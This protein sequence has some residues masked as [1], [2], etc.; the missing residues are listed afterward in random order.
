MAAALEV[1]SATSRQTA[2]GAK[3]ART[4]SRSGDSSLKLTPAHSSD[5]VEG[6]GDHFEG[7]AAIR[8]FLENWFGTYEELEFGLEEVR[9]LGKGVC[10]CRGHSE[11][12]SGWQ[13]RSRGDNARVGLRLRG[14]L[15]RAT[16]DLRTGRG[17][18]VAERLAEEPG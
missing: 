4:A 8:S 3:L 14:R 12:S 11:R 18:V 7:R 10:V 2:S 13:R 9:D 5:R 16:Y 17:R 6:G 15:D 1:V